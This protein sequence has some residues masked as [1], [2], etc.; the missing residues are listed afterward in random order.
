MEEQQVPINHQFSLAPV[1]KHPTTVWTELTGGP[2]SE[3][4]ELVQFHS[5]WGN[6]NTCGS[7]HTVDGKAYAGEL[8]F[9]HWNR[10]KFPSCAEA[11]PSPSGLT[12]IAVF[13]E[14]E[15]NPEMDKL[16]DV[17]SKIPS[18]DDRT[19]LPEDLD[20]VAMYP[21][22]DTWP[23]KYPQAGGQH[24]SPV[25][26]VTSSIQSRSYDTPLTWKYGPG[27]CKTIVNTGCGWRVDV[28]GNDSELT[29][30]PLSGRTQLVQFHSPWAMTIPLVFPAHCGTEKLL[31]E[32]RGK[33]TLR[34]TN[35]GDVC[36]KIHRRCELNTPEDFDPVA[37]DFPLIIPF[38]PIP[39]LLLLRLVMKVSPGLC[40]RIPSP[41][42]RNR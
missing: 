31:L 38:G 3:S 39:D 42:L 10:D 21:G 4:Y 7:E 27:I 32:G 2:L 36:P 17:L 35:W 1:G 8:H 28:Q 16:C 6:D 29:G 12:V 24:Q 41:C 11:V 30:G 33:R 14:G 25:D 5:H 26:I 9:V 23:S 19:E 34:W 40:S 13:L 22:P 20:P 15:K 37:G 18:K